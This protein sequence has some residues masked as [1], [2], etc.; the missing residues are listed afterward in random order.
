MGLTMASIKRR[1]NGRW[2]A[3]YR[4]HD[5]KEHARHFARKIDAQRWLDGETVKLRTGR[6]VD[7]SAGRV[8]F[9]DWA[10]A[11]VE[12]QVWEPGTVESATNAIDSVPFA[13]KDIDRI[14]PVDIEAWVKSMDKKGLAASTVRTRFNY[15]RGVFLAAVRDKVIGTAPTDGIRLPRVR[16]HDAAMTIPTPEQVKIA[17]DAADAYFATFIAICAFAGLRLGETAG[18]QVGD[19]DFL[20]RTISVRRQVQGTNKTNARE[21]APKAGS[22]RDVYVPELLINMI[23]RHLTDYGAWGDDRWL[24]TSGGHLFQRTSAGDRWR[25]VRKRIGMDEFTLH[26]FRHFFASG[27]IA[28]GCDVVTVQRALGHSSPSITL[29]TY[30]HLW[31]TAE[32]KTR[33]AATA[34]ME[35]V[36]NPVADSVRTGDGQ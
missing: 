17:L 13:S 23:S 34:V 31:P 21:A 20:R 8:T 4:D 11:Y 28:E 24:F 18:L 15:V 33:A 2:R 32:D 6:W 7:P 26:D 27:L 9:R 22:E 29:N 30:S 14:A 36:L 3:R 12:R 35:S 10:A 5:G 25:A 19:V 1:E 16:R